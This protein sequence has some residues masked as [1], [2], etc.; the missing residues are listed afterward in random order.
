MN[1]VK[2]CKRGHVRTAENVNK[3]G[4]CKECLKITNAKWKAENAEK[5]SEYKKEWAERNPEKIKSI[6]RENHIKN[7]EKKKEYQKRNRESIRKNALRYRHRNL[8]KC[9][10]TSSR[11]QK[12][13]PD[14]SNAQTRKRQAAKL[15]RT[16]PWLTKDQV[17]EISAFYLTAEFMSN[18]TCT[19]HHVDHIVPL[20]GRNVSGLH[21]P[22][23]LQV[24]TAEENLR[25]G[26]SFDPEGGL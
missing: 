13:N 11:W 15:K 20:Q 5:V 18:A 14:K 24:L 25:K 26:N 3:W 19:P 12:E 16:P 22:W 21:V 8:E 2:Y 1:T 7:K 9:R 10:A 17:E 6:Q 23:N 4:A